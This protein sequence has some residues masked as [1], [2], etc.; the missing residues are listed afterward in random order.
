[1]MGRAD[2]PLP[3]KTMRAKLVSTRIY[4]FLFHT[5]QVAIRSAVFTL[6]TWQRGDH[7]SREDRKEKQLMK[8]KRFLE[9]IS[10]RGAVR[11][12]PLFR[13]FNHD[14]YAVV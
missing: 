9:M 12:A 8:K 5:S 13:G 1:M 7:N 3:V 4:F 6:T 2:P 11:S 14:R 10:E